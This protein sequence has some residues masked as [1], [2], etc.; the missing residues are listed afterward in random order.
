MKIERRAG[1][2]PSLI[3]LAIVILAGLG[4]FI[5]NTFLHAPAQEQKVQKVPLVAE[6][7]PA[8]APQAPLVQEVEEAPVVEEVEPEPILPPLP[9]LNAS[10]SEIKDA[11]SGLNENILALIVNDELI[12]KF[13]RA[14]NG[15]HEGKIV[16][17][18]R[19]VNSPEGTFAATDVGMDSSGEMRVFK[20]S[21]EN[22]NRYEQHISVL[23]ALDPKT[24]VAMYLRYYPLLQSAYEELGLREPSFHV[25]MLSAIKNATQKPSIAGYDYYATSAEQEKLVQPSVMFAYQSKPIE[26]LSGLEKLKIRMGP[27]NA[28]KL[29]SWL[30]RAQGELVILDL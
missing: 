1:I 12:R 29:E 28:L 7:P 3:V 30:Q 25:V 5:W 27:R 11:L 10:D 18:F 19:P 21:S 4:F 26:A 9:A 14:V 20:I 23:T 22:F 6:T 2:S 24:A 8:S 16:Q 17:T 13:V 15:M